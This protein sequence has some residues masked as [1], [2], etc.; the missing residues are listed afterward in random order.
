MAIDP[1]PPGRDWGATP[2]QREQAR[3]AF[4]CMGKEYERLLQAQTP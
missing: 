2:E 1:L 4:S 3:Y